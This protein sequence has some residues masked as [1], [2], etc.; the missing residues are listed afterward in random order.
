MIGIP[1]HIEA[2]IAALQPEGARPENLRGIT[3]SEWRD[4][5]GRWE[6]VRFLIPLR[7]ACA[8]DLPEWV[9][10]SIDRNLADNAERFARIKDIY[11]SFADGL[12]DAGVEHLVLKGFAQCPDYTEDPRYR[13]QSDID[14]FCPPESLFRAR[15]L[16]AS[17]GYEPSPGL[18]HLRKD[19]LQAMD[20]KTSWTWRGNFFDPKMPVSWE[21]HYRL[22]DDTG[23]RISPKGLDQFWTRRVKRD[24]QGFTFPSLAPEDNLAYSALNMLRDALRGPA[25]LHLVYELACFLHKQAGNNRFWRKWSE[26]HDDSLR[27]LEAI[28]F[29]L[30][31]Q[32]FHCHLSAEVQTE[33]DRLPAAVHRWFELYADSTLALSFGSDNN[34]DTLW[35][36]IALLDSQRDKQTVFLQRLL[37]TR[38]PAVADPR[39][40]DSA[41]N[42][43]N[44]AKALKRRVRQIRHLARR[45]VYHLALIPSTLWHGVR[46]CW[47]TTE[48]GGDFLNFLAATFLFNLG[49]YVFFFLYNLYLLD[50]GYQENFLGMATSA[51][52][53]GSLAGTLPAGVLAQRMGLRKALLVCFTFVSL[54]S[55]LRSILV[56]PTPLLVCSFFAGF[57]GVVW[58]IT[59]VPAIAQLTTEKNRTSGFSI[60][61]FLGTAVGI[62]GGQAAGRLPGWLMH[63]VH[64]LTPGSAKEVSLL[65]ASTIIG[66]SILPASRLRFKSALIP[67]KKTYCWNPFLLRFLVVMAIWSLG[68]G[69]FSPFFTAYFSRHLHMRLSHI[70]TVDSLSD[71]A[72]LVAFLAA[73]AFF[74][75][76][77]LGIGIAYTQIMTAISL[78]C[79]AFASGIAAAST[80]YIAYVAFQWMCEPAIYG[81]LMNKLAS[82]EHAGASALNSLVI[83]ASQALATAVAGALFIRVGYPIVIAITALVTLVSAL[84]FWLLGKET[85]WSSPA[86]KQN[87]DCLGE[88]SSE[89]ETAVAQTSRN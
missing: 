5:L 51:V 56:S 89:R 76:F 7:Q 63:M 60:A 57:V 65:A 81:L 11:C 3:D 38:I 34:K 66:L 6:V 49:M 58:A 50:L 4:L 43:E 62:M 17:L 1:A 82:R 45:V 88:S 33:I 16:L 22:W 68:T 25:T 77:G 72:Q 71:V 47:S 52:T 30:A 19:H 74:K 8:N 26:L 31:F 78:A 37:P 42:Q 32:C 86:P 69:G 28:S 29:R 75:K 15:D 39:F 24:L 61:F 59:F 9:C 64:G 20:R 85:F 46:W 23:F 10:L 41:T 73:P 13:L 53:M 83:S 79:L 14:I 84:F 70:G 80:I 12:R 18:H 2:L 36:H 35:L 21:L 44:G 67:E 87:L 27:R 54:F 40:E 55:A 48:F